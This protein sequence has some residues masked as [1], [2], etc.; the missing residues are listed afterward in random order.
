MEVHVLFLGCRTSAVANAVLE[1]VNKLD[2]TKEGLPTRD[3][4]ESSMHLV[5]TLLP[6][7]SGSI[8]LILC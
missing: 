3:A 8:H 2:F 6:F 4:M 7:P 1:Q 5:Y